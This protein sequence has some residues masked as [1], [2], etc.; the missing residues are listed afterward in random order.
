MVSW[1]VKVLEAMMKRVVSGIEP[2]ERLGDVRAVDIGDEVDAQLRVWHR[3]CSAS[4]TIT[5][6]R[7][8]PPMPMLTMS[9][10]RLPV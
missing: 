5:G 2:L 4:V 1:V 3:A 9:V 7:S 8:E 10:M 6:P